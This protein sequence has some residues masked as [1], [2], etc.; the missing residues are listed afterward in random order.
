MPETR[1]E[2]S[3]EAAA[4]PLRGRTA[5]VLAD[6]PS[7]M[8][9]LPDRA[10]GRRLDVARL[11]AIPFVRGFALERATAVAPERGEMMTVAAWAGWEVLGLPPGEPA[12][13][14]MAGEIRRGLEEGRRPD[15]VVLAG[16]D[17]RLAEAVEMALAGGIPVWILTFPGMLHRRP[18]QV[19][20]SH[21]RRVR[22][23]WAFPAAVWAE[24]LADPP[25]RRRVSRCR[26][27]PL[28]I[29]PLLEW[30]AEALRSGWSRSLPESLQ[31][32]LKASRSPFRAPEAG[33]AWVMG[34]LGGSARIWREG[35]TL[36]LM[37]ESLRPSGADLSPEAMRALADRLWADLFGG[38]EEGSE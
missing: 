20:M 24:E 11:L 30:G 4:A 37:P 28:E 35:E 18:L 26:V 2:L 1:I 17:E 15:L 3:N 12:G 23:V 38:G 33:L 29:A 19:V 9:G 34:H 16:G 27:W 14:W 5:W 36:W 7:L 21:P 32:F 10:I 31:P 8:A 13:A 6:L 22:V 25:T